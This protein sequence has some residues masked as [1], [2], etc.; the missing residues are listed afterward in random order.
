MRGLVREYLDGRLS[1]RQFVKRMVAL[2]VS[3]ASA[4]AFI[5][6]FEPSPAFGEQVMEL[7]DVT[8]GRV[9]AEMLRAWNTKYVFGIPGTNEVGFIDALVDIPELH[10][11]MGLHEGPVVCMADGYARL[12]G[13]PAFVNLHSI[14]GTAY[15]LGG[16][17][18]AF[19]DNTP[20]VVTVG[21][22]DTR[23]RGRGAF[24]ES[25]RLTT[26][27]Q[28]YTKWTWDVLRG[29]KIPEVMER[30]FKIATT[31][32]GGPVFITFSKDL[33]KE[34][35]DR[36]EILPLDRFRISMGIHPDPKLVEVAARLL[37]EADHPLIMAGDE[38]SRYGGM[39]ELVELAELLAAP[40]V[41]EFITG[42]AL[43][44]FPTDHPLY[45]GPLRPQLAYPP[46]IDVFLNVG[47]KMFSEFDYSPEHI[48]PR[49]T[50]VIHMGLN[51]THMARTYP[52][53]VALVTHVQA[54]LAAL[55][56]EIKGL[57]TS[58][59]WNR[60]KERRREVENERRRWRAQ[61][62]EEARRDWDAVPISPARLA[63]ELNGVL[64]PQG[65]VVSELVTSDHFLLSYIDF[66]TS[67]RDRTYVASSGGC[68]GWG[69]G[70]ACGAKL[71]QPHREVTLLVGDGSFQ[72]GV[73]GV[74]TAARY[75]I[76]I[77]IVIWN[78]REYQA[79]RMAL[80]RYGRRAVAAKRYI[81]SHLGDPEIDHV[82]IARGYGVSGERVTD[83]D[84][85]KSAWKRAR[86]ANREG[87]PYVL[88]VLI[89][90]R[91][92]DADRYGYETFSVA[93]L[94]GRTRPGK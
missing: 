52:V 65:I 42:H 75:D 49:Q 74:W 40:V 68:L 22:Q 62:A 78:N 93:E 55:I 70:A 53:D 33:W 1:R 25:P 24:L 89:K 69:I 61:L 91:F 60:L 43:I 27:P 51:T 41:G 77:T 26:I 58:A 21:R 86:R 67:A 48:I 94:A 66:H 56:S 23:L 11:I 80:T 19:Q 87:K 36:A 54:G 90:R 57:M 34:K 16:L 20:L 37:V 50:K 38:I 31:P 59:R 8:G 15:G 9:V 76:P 10:Y 46:Q 32:P 47:G 4:R 35:V 28:P 83:P 72:F 84:E 13:R 2:G 85:I 29:E 18:A 6:S 5:A 92:R 64:D 14:A 88:D 71:A 82:G 73:Q 44:N 30:G 3:A 45:L 12:S 63:M 39:S 7:N 17:V 81:G 79:N